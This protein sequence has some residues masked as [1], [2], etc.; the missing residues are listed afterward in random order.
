[1]ELNNSPCKKLQGKHTKYRNPKT[2]N[3]KPQGPTTSLPSF[4]LRQFATMTHYIDDNLTDPNVLQPYRSNVVETLMVIRGFLHKKDRRKTTHNQAHVLSISC[5]EM[6]EL[7]MGDER[8]NMTTDLYRSFSFRKFRI[9]N[10]TTE[11]GNDG[12]L[13]VG[14][15]ASSSSSSGTRP[16]LLI[17]F[18]ISQLQIQIVLGLFR[19]FCCRWNA[20]EIATPDSQAKPRDRSIDRSA[21]SS[22]TRSRSGSLQTAKRRSSKPHP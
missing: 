8:K 22:L 21:C 13:R 12:F 18:I 4:T 17:L 14:F 3:L 5:L 2:L 11:I 19:H 9:R 6:N 15:S 20:T 7:G 16:L 1:M 10:F